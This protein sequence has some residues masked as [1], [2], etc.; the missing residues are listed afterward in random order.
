M[1]HV[2]KLHHFW[3]LGARSVQPGGRLQIGREIN[4]N[5]RDLR[6]TD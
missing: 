4:K 6:R 1:Y 3:K 5:V 2:V